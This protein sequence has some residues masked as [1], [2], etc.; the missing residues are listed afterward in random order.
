MPSLDRTLEILNVAITNINNLLSNQQ[1]AQEKQLETSKNADY[2][3]RKALFPEKHL[4]EYWDE[5]EFKLKTCKNP[6]EAQKLQE[7]L[8]LK[9]NFLIPTS[10]DIIT[11]CGGG[12]GDLRKKLSRY[13]KVLVKHFMSD[14]DYKPKNF[15][16]I[17]AAVDA[18]TAYLYNLSRDWLVKSNDAHE[19]AL[20]SAI[21]IQQL[22]IVVGQ[23]SE[24]AGEK[25]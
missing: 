15:L 21:A 4:T 12:G 9:P 5:L 20:S 7:Q 11:G 22:R 18:Y 1:Q 19:L 2:H 13:L 8:K 24:K 10:I 3:F 23:E 6:E 17:R 14:E 16:K 25:E